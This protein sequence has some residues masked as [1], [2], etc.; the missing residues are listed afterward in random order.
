M[1]KLAD[2]RERITF[3]IDMMERVVSAQET[4]LDAASSDADARHQTVPDTLAWLVSAV[5]TLNASLGAVDALIASGRLALIEAPGVR[6]SLSGIRGAIG[7]AAEGQ[8]QARSLYFD[9]LVPLTRDRFNRSGIAHITDEFF[10]AGRVPGRGLVS[11]SMVGYPISPA[12][13]AITLE[14]RLHYQVSLGE[15]RQLLDEFEQLRQ[16]TADLR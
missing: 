1:Q 5:P 7:D 8:V 3:Q 2:N 12:I 15:M 10:S 13:F 14:R 9:Q 16:M 4:L 11:H 6:A